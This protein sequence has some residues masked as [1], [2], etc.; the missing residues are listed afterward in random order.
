M[1][2][3]T[4]DNARHFKRCCDCLRDVVHELTFVTEHDALSA[5]AVADGVCV[6]AVFHASRAIE[7]TCQSRGTF[8]LSTDTLAKLLRTATSEQYVRLSLEGYEVRF[9]LY[10]ERN[11]SRFTMPTLDAP[12]ARLPACPSTTPECRVSLRTD[13]LRTLLRDLRHVGERVAIEVVQGSLLLFGQSDN[14]SGEVVTRDCSIEGR[15]GPYGVYPVGVLQHFLKA[16]HVAPLV[17]L[18]FFPSALRLTLAADATLSLT[19]TELGGSL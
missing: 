1:F 17:V 9:E 2:T 14:T 6:R 5:F 3:L 18:A 13:H 7:Y 11:A 19:L 15:E 4:L 8:G 12:P 16:Q 10:T